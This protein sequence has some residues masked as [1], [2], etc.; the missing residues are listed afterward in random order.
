MLRRLSSA[1]IKFSELTVR[2]AI[3]AV[4][5]ALLVAP[6]LAAAE[7]VE[8]RAWP[9]PD[10]ARIVFDWQS[11][12]GYEARNEG[13]SVV[14]E[15]E[16]PIESDFERLLTILSDHVASARLE[17]EGR[18]LVLAV[19]SNY[20]LRTSRSNNS[21]VVDLLYAAE[22][23]AAPAA[24]ANAPVVQ[25]GG[26]PAAVG[27]RVGVHDEYTRVVF[28]WV[29]NVDYTVEKTG[30]DV[31]IQFNRP[32]SFALG[33]LGRG[34][35]PLI[36]SAQAI[37]ESD[38]VSVALV[39]DDGTRLRHFRDGTKVVVDII[40]GAE[41]AT[42]A[43][44]AA[45][46]QAAAPEPAP[47]PPRQ[48]PVAPPP[49]AAAPAPPAEPV[50]TLA[51]VDEPRSPAEPVGAPIPLTSTESTTT[52]AARRPPDGPIA[53]VTVGFAN[54]EAGATIVFEWEEEV[55]AA[56]YSRAG[57]YW[58]VFDQLAFADI[59]QIPPDVEASVFLAEQIDIERGTALRF[60]V[61]DGLNASVDRVGTLWRVDFAAQAEKPINAI[62]VRREPE[63][64]SGARVFLPL[65]DMG[66]RVDITD[67]EVGDRVYVVPLPAPGLGVAAERNF[68]EFQLLASAQ[69]VVVSP[70]A[71]LI[72]VRPL[73][74]GVEIYTPQGLTLSGLSEEEM[75]T[76]EQ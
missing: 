19:R 44:P 53:N 55:A 5:A 9:H 40:R 37:G 52:R 23:D 50:E 32:A 12:V 67:P 3:I 57:Y 58:A 31:S 10:F 36:E 25:A 4:W 14:L 17:D 21:I 6:N 47:P 75:R 66:R 28:D 73:R 59:L 68:A 72:E 70:G 15:F 11:P 34:E 45:Q 30:R 65:E 27:I 2:L 56:V 64:R 26:G 38:R 1:R 51:Q 20:G 76:A 42:P 74:K 61:R 43:A 13:A 33:R 18:R 62:E 24:A 8:T 29:R 49:A 46:Q 69:G 63:L 22:N 48:D 41:A 60:K 16:R 7:P 35:R 54:T 71:D 39:V